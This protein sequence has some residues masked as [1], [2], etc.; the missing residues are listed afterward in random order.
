MRLQVNVYR[1]A[2]N[3]ASRPAATLAALLGAA[4]A[5]GAAASVPADAPR[6]PANA[7]HAGPILDDFQLTLEPGWRR[8]A[9]GPFY[10]DEHAETAE[11]WAVPPFFSGF[12]SPGAQA[13]EFSFLYPVMSSNRYGQQYQWQF[14][15]LLSFAGGPSPTEEFRDRFTLFPLYF[16]QRSSVPGENYTAYGPFY[17]HLQHR[18]FR[19]EISYVMFPLY[20]ET[21]R[22]DVVTDNYLFPI[23]HQRQGDGLRGWQA[24]P[25]IG[26]EHKEPTTRTNYLQMV[27]DV[28]G[29]DRAFLM[30]PFLFDAVSGIGS[31]NEEH[32]TGALPFFE[33]ARSPLRD[34]TTLAW[35]FLS[36]VVD[37]GQQYEEWNAPWPLVEYVRGPGKETTR[38]WPL[39]SHAANS[40]LVSDFVLWPVYKLNRIISPPLD[41]R[42]VR[43]L[44]FEYR[45]VIDRNTETGM[46]RRHS[47]LWPL[48]SY[49]R[50]L[51]GNR[52]L[53]VLAVIE[54]FVPENPVV[55]RE[56]A[57]IYSFW[58][59]EENARTGASSRSLLWNLY[60]EERTPLTRRTS[61][62]FGLWQRESGPEGRRSRLFFV[63]LGPSPRPA[64]PA[65][66]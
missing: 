25:F 43:I 61:F 12:R 22:A 27:E 28:P 26:H 11:T 64:G 13:S 2:A 29:H 34:S 6:L 35:P 31:T 44:F 17:G 32:H 51:K 38:L 23:F 10:F 59:S 55:E 1:A 30:W 47:T 3:S 58:R 40:N 41:R 63:P 66:H 49:H 48:Y 16:Q 14:F 53:Q 33:I 19:D 18:L 65:K 57:P 62:F 37:R 24:F 9:A 20:S 36:H 15:Q 54:P 21:R 46:S 39:F 56:Y 7:T 50:D 60:R 4:V 5:A 8:E 45:D 42:D 52:R